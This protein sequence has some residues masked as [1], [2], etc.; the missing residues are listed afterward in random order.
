[1]RHALSS[2]RNFLREPSAL[3]SSLIG[4]VRLSFAIHIYLFKILNFWF[5]WFVYISA[6]GL[7]FVSLER[8]RSPCFLIAGMVSCLRNMRVAKSSVFCNSWRA[9]G[10]DLLLLLLFFLTVILGFIQFASVLPQLYSWIE[11][12]T[13]LKTGRHNLWSYYSSHVLQ[14]HD[15][16]GVD[17]FRMS[18]Y[19]ANSAC[20]GRAW[21]ERA[22]SGHYF[23]LCTIP[24]KY[25]DI[26]GREPPH[27]SVRLPSFKVHH[28]ILWR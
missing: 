20:A 18:K 19:F 26:F 7:V 22:Q 12:S 2:L 4:H 9:I 16:F 6:L 21:R 3:E 5:R 27:G 15:R 24:T 11:R 14:L 13:H 23:F 28:T 1:M 10:S 17:D 8:W 25:S